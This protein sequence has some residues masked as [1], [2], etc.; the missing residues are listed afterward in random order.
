[1]NQYDDEYK[2]AL[3][4]CLE[5]AFLKNVVPTDPIS[6]DLNVVKPLINYIRTLTPNPEDFI[7]SKPVY[8]WWDLTS[9]CNFR[10]VHC[11]YNDSEYSDNTDLSEK[12]SMKLADELINDFGL[13]EIMLTGGEIF[14]KPYLIK[15]VQCLF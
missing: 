2:L 8:A 7:F 4:Y 14:L 10:C 13:V 11:L 15:L 5:R 1:M 12:Q 3:R 6:I 9:A